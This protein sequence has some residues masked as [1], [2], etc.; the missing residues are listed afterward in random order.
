MWIVAAGMAAVLGLG[1]CVPPL[2]RPPVAESAQY[3]PGADGVG[4]VLYPKA[5]NG[6]YDVGNYDLSVRY[7]PSSGMLT[8]TAIITATATQNLSR[9]D[10]DLHGL[11]VGTVKVDGAPATFSRSGDELVITPVVHLGQGRDFAVTVAYSG[12]PKPYDEPDLGV[13]GFL[14]RDD[15]VVAI[16]EP[17]VAADWFPVNDHPKDKAT[18]TIRIAAPDGLD[19]LSNGI[20]QS[21]QSAAGYTTSTWVVSA[22]MASYLATMVIGHYRVVQSTHDGRPVIT[23]VASSLPTYIDAQLARTPEVIDFLTT[24]FGPYPFDSE[25]G[26]VI[27]EPRVRY[28]L[29]NQTRPIY[30]DAFFGPRTDSMYVI[31]HELAH[32]W[33]GDSVSITQWQD[34]WLNEGFATYAEWLWN[35]HTGSETV[36]SAFARTYASADKLWPI[37]PGKPPTQAEVFGSSVY[38]RG[39]M[40][41][42]ALRVKVGDTAFFAILRDWAAQ[43]RF[44]NGTSVQFMA[45]AEK[46]SGLSLKPLFDA[47]LFGTTKPPLP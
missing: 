28:A 1:G 8:G 32:Q 30:A 46:D 37:P 42:Q 23:A 6:G 4:D 9:F 20:K 41:L 24:Q 38:D 12:V 33:Y 2:H 11:Q 15:S 26:I 10:L 13:D 21:S 16:G 7:D 39:A 14:A 17:E 34:I 35:A 22:P 40:V 31:A 36:A 47:W 25:G 5:G 27:D 43:H 44:G 29:E 18:Y 19:V 45:L 3:S